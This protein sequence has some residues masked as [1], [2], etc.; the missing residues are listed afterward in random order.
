MKYLKL[1]EGFSNV[2]Y[3]S[4]KEF[5]QR[6]NDIKGVLWK[7]YFDYKNEEDREYYSV[8]DINQYGKGS[9]FCT[10][11]NCKSHY[12]DNVGYKGYDEFILSDDAKICVNNYDFFLENEEEIRRNCD[13]FYD[14]EYDTFG[15]IIWNRDL[16]NK[17]D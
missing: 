7:G 10:T 8:S 6:Y 1:Y 16:V 14:P 15:L 3:I 9:Y 11:F 13:G 5:L 12:S 4:G 2:D 17:I